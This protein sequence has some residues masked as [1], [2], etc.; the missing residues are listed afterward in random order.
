MESPGAVGEGE[1]EVMYFTSLS[2][3][4]NYLDNQVKTLEDNVNLIE[5]NIA[6]LEPRLAGFQSLLGVIKKLVGKENILLT[7]AIEI[8]GLKIVIDPNP[9]DEYDTLKESLDAMKDK[10][11]VLRK[12]R[13][14]IRILVTTAKLDVPVLVQMRAGVPVKVLIGVSR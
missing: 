9:I 3:F 12:V 14:L 11:T 13:E 10:L 1:L 5:K 8:T 7:P 6:Q 2:E 4:M